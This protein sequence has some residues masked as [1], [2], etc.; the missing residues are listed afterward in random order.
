[1]KCTQVG[2]VRS[3]RIKKMRYMYCSLWDVTEVTVL[4]KLKLLKM[5]TGLIICHHSRISCIISSY[6]I[7]SAISRISEENCPESVHSDK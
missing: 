5:I 6:R 3:N 1:M 2:N 4:L 7:Y